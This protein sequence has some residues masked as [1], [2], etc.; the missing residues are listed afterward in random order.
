[1][2]STLKRAGAVVLVVLPLFVPEMIIELTWLRPDAAL[3]IAGMLPAL[4]GWR[5]APSYG[6]AFVPI[7]AAFNAAAVTVFGHPVATTVVVAIL[8]VLVGLSAIKGVHRVTSF[9]AAQPAITVIAGYHTVSLSG[10][11]PGI[12]GQAIMSAVTV[13]IGAIWALLVAAVLLRGENSGPPDPVPAPAVALYVG[14]LLLL[15]TPIAFVASMW[16][17]NTTA[18]W[19]MLT[20]L[21]VTRPSYAESWTMIMQ[22]AVGTVI[23]GVLAAG[24]AVL[25]SDTAILITLGTLA[26][27]VALVLLLLHVRYVY[28]AILITA[29]IVLLNAQRAN[30]FHTAANYLLYTITGVVLVA[31]VVASVQAALGRRTAAHRRD[32]QSCAATD[33]R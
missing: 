25:V 8:A 32:G 29:A 26:M 4:F 17:L 9:L 21:L 28:F 18:G 6:W 1:M 10:V 22:R 3:L 7:A 13:A 33:G 2:L 27:V 16:F 20:I 14:A 12:F 5:Y 19:I 24:G 11:T 23:G 31:G 30:V 15:L